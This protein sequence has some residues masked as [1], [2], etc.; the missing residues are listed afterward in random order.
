M[1]DSIILV[2]DITGTFAFAVSGA[3]AAAEKKFDLFGAVFLGFVTAIGGG[4]MR[5]M[6]LG[7]TPVAWLQ[8][9]RIFYTIVIA[10]AFTFLFRPTIVRFTKALFLFDTIG[11]SVFT[12]IGLQKGLGVNIHAPIAVMMGI[13]TAVMGGI[14]RDVLCNDIPLIFHKE[15]YATACLLGGVI[16]LALLYLNVSESV[17]IITAATSIFI[18]R[19]LSVRYKWSLPKFK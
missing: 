3:L 6:M 10:V 8:D 17:I 7:N 1:T 16:Y 2:L 9:I 5:D 4:T 12:I 15:I 11:I 13:T 19:T 18:V 14:I